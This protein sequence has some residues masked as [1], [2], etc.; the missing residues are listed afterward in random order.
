MMSED[1]NN[2]KACLPGHTLVLCR[3]GQL[4]YSDKRGVAPM[5]DRIESGID[6][7]GYSAADTVVGKAAA[8]MF[9]KSG[10]IAVYAGVLSEKGLLMLRKHGI[11]TEYAELV[12]GI[13]NR[14]GTGNCPM[15]EAVMNLDDPDEC[16]AAIKAKIASL[17]AHAD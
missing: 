17:R 3:E 11:Y 13:K 5:I 1:L 10:I 6:L 16:Y 15:E 2:A 7:Q 12:D 14:Q 9:V 4:L 8:S